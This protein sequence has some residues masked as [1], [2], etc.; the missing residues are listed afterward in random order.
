M[1]AD[2]SL[3]VELD[4]VVHHATGRLVSGEPEESRARHLVWAKYTG[5][6]DGDL[7]SWR[8]SATVVALDLLR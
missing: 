4:G 7:T 8:D 5:G 1:V 6:P 3:T 2:P